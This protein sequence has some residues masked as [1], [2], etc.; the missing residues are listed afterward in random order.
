M[1]GVLVLIRMALDLQHDMVSIT[2]LD[3]EV[4]PVGPFLALHLVRDSKA[5]LIVAYIA[6]DNAHPRHLLDRESGCLFPSRSMA[7]HVVQVAR[8]CRDDRKEHLEIHMHSR[9]GLMMSI[10]VGEIR[11][12]SLSL[13]WFNRPDQLVSHS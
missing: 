5:T 9:F 13:V 10:Q 2:H 1:L 4:A 3:D 11:W 7:G 6:L 12:L 8:A